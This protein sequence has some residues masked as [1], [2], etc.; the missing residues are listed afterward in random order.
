MW[1]SN[2]RTWD[3]IVFLT[4][5]FYNKRNPRA[6]IIPIRLITSGRI[7]NPPAD[8]RNSNSMVIKWRSSRLSDM[9]FSL[10]SRRWFHARNCH[11]Q[12]YSHAARAKRASR[13]YIILLSRNIER[14]PEC[15]NAR[16]MRRQLRT[17]CRGN[18]ALSLNHMCEWIWIKKIMTNF[19]SFGIS[20]VLK[21]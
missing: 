4:R 3:R 1:F 6:S 5:K 11:R 19:V 17:G 2:S 12:F 14:R 7:N 13:L 18:R 15:W 16:V 8:R 20:A 21:F 9:N 10:P